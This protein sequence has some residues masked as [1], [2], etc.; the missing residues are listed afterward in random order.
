MPIAYVFNKLI[1]DEMVK[2]TKPVELSLF[3]GR[4]IEDNDNVRS[5]LKIYEESS[6]ELLSIK[7]VSNPVVS[8]NYDVNHFPAILFINDEGKEIIRYLAK[9]FGAEILPFIETLTIFSGDKN[10]YEVVIKENIEKIKP[11]I[12]KVMI[13][14]SCAYC[15]EI[16]TF[17]NKFAI[18]SNG[19]IKSVII[20]I[21]A[22]PDIGESYDRT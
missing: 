7:E 22:H 17:V 16:I 14:N 8:K 18:A 20:N 5:I 1:R 3:M 21:M 6:N 13:T 15:P 11:S 19:I 2:L 4:N 9:P 12:I 10:Y